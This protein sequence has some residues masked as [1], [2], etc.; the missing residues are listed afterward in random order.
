MKQG[1]HNMNTMFGRAVMAAGVT[2]AL[3]GP[4]QAAER[5]TFDKSHTSLLF[6]INHA[7]FSNMIG[8][9]HDYDGTLVLDE[10]NPEHSSVEVTIR[11]ASVDT[12]VDALDEKLHK[13]DFFNTEEYPTASFKST[14]VVKTGEKTADITGDFTLLG[15]TKPLTLRA[16]LNKLDMNKWS[17]KQTAGFSVEAT[18]TRSDWGMGYLVPDVGDEVT[19]R[20]EA[21][22]QKE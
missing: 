11:P 4:V 3:A 10:A 7:G 17:Q 18:L 21:E 5:Y 6:F 19:L 2:L 12:D 15:V 13:A 20:I 8:E 22:L 9:F 14:K 1:Y 16:T